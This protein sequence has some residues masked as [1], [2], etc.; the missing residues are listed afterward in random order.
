GPDVGRAEPDPPE[1][2]AVEGAPSERACREMSLALGPLMGNR[3]LALPLAA[4]GE[5]APVALA[6]LQA[7]AALHVHCLDALGAIDLADAIEIGSIEPAI[8]DMGQWSVSFGR[9]DSGPALPTR[10][11]S[12][13]AFASLRNADS[14]AWNACW[15]FWSRF[16]GSD[17]VAMRCSSRIHGSAIGCQMTSALCAIHSESLSSPSANVRRLPLAT[18]HR[19]MPSRRSNR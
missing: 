16:R 5:R 19:Q 4:P 13:R 18:R 1:M 15:R 17:S 8:T 10:D 12:A 6:F 9:A 11:A 14:G 3:V 7:G 2:L